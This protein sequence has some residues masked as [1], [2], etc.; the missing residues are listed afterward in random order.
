MQQCMRAPIP[1][2]IDPLSHQPLLCTYTLIRF[3]FIEK[4]L[5]N[6]SLGSKILKFYLWKR[7]EK[8]ITVCASEVMEE[9]NT[10]KKTAQRVHY[11]LTI[12]CDVFPE[13]ITMD[14]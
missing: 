5:F 6:N 14:S 3:I 13:S 4:N 9:H 8:V 12:N 1:S 11:H 7:R 10:E 2:L